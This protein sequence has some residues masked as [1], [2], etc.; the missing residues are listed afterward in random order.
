[1][2][3]CVCPPPVQGHQCFSVF[4]GR[5][6]TLLL[7][8]ERPR[9]PQGHHARKAACYARSRKLL[10]IDIYYNS[11]ESGYGVTWHLWPMRFCRSWLESVRYRYMLTHRATSRRVSCPFGEGGTSRH[12]VWQDATVVVVSGS[13]DWYRTGLPDRQRAAIIRPP[14]VQSPNLELKRSARA[15]LRLITF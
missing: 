6:I 13:S 15:P 14:E 3:R 9:P 5:D 7:T 4:E 10:R 1:M 2:Y 8:C 12:G 11:W